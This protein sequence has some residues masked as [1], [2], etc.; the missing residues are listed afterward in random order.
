[1]ENRHQ[2]LPKCQDFAAKHLVNSADR[3][4]K[5]KYLANKKYSESKGHKKAESKYVECSNDIAQGVTRS[6]AKTDVEKPRN[7]QSESESIFFS[8]ETVSCDF[9]SSLLCNSPG[10]V[11]CSPVAKS[12][13][14]ELSSITS[15]M[16]NINSEMSKYCEYGQPW[17]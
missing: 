4:R 1:M 17:L 10:L 8:P 16:E 14:N 13:V 7:I 12:P 2:T 15:G 11:T 5:A 3:I 9:N 6:M